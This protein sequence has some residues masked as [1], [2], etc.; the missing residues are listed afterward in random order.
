MCGEHQSE[1]NPNESVKKWNLKIVEVGVE[2]VKFCQHN[3]IR[4]C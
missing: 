1:L 2:C 4:Y 3:I